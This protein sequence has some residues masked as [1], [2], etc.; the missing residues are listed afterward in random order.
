MQVDPSRAELS[1]PSIFVSVKV[2]LLP[3]V[4]QDAIPPDQQEE[5]SFLESQ[6]PVSDLVLRGLW[7]LSGACVARFSDFS[8]LWRYNRWWKARIAARASAFRMRFDMESGSS[9]YWSSLKPDCRATSSVT[10][11]TY[12]GRGVAISQRQG[13]LQVAQVSLMRALR[14]S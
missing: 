1:S 7:S 8:R 13:M 14:A 6:Q 12:W 5:H 3:I 9:A 2:Q 4:S 10:S 11:W